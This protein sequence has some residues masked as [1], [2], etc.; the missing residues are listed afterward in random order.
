MEE[1]AGIDCHGFLLNV[2]ALRARQPG[3][4]NYTAHFFLYFGPATVLRRGKAHGKTHG[5]TL[6]AAAL[7]A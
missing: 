7:A 4:K 1:L 5:K 6:L 3:L 2:P